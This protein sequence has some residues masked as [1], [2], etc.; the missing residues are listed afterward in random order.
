VTDLRGEGDLSVVDDF[1]AELKRI[2]RRPDPQF[3]LLSPEEV[4]DVLARCRT[5][6]WLEPELAH[7]MTHAMATVLDRV[8]DRVRP[9]VVL[10][11]PIDRYVKDVLARLAEARGAPYMELT[12]AAV[13]A[14]AMLIQRGRLLEDDFEPP[15]ENVDEAIALLAAPNF[16]PSYVPRRSRY[17]ALKFVRTL[18]YFRARALAFRIISRIKRDPLNLHYLDAQPFL[19]HKCRWRDIRVVRMC[20]PDWRR[21]LQHVAPS[22]RV[23]FGLQL[24]PEASIDYWIDNLDLVANEALVVEAAQAYAGSGYLVLVKD[25]PLQFGF[26]R[27]QLLEQLR[28]IPNVVIVP[29]EVGG[30]ELL[31]LCAVNFTC[32][33]TLGL[34][35]ALLGKVAVGT[36]SYYTNDDD[37]VIFRKRSEIPGLPARSESCDLGA[38]ALR[39]RQERIV[40]KLLRGSFEGDFFSFRDFD[41]RRPEGA[42]QLA[43]AL[44]NRLDRLI[45]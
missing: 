4:A 42:L 31:D 23:L 24:F 10:S 27:T 2:R 1:Y 43:H 41:P 12:A 20:E 44:G 16:V 34:Q 38:V 5:L 14:A 40:R 21:H 32:T 39:A 45:P 6:R 35:A 28:A 19:G 36:D 26:R 15:S 25:H 3:S 17:N 9:R 7:A 18:G 22:R 37:F 33:G 11:F 30:N 29:Y 8:L 13:P